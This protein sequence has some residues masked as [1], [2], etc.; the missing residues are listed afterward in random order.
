MQVKG[1]D[2]GGGIKDVG[3]GQG[4]PGTKERLQQGTSPPKEQHPKT[5]E[6]KRSVLFVEQSRRG[7]AMRDTLAKLESLLGYRFKVV[8]SGGT[9]FALSSP[10]QTL[11]QEVIVEGMTVTL[12]NRR[13]RKLNPVPDKTSSMR[14][15]VSNVM[16]RRRKSRSWRTRGWSHPSTLERAQEV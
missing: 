2:G 14:A 13:L 1:G 15:T 10:I 8:E 4:Y 12:A 9:S 11:G 6:R 16:T 3:G 7:T 5:D